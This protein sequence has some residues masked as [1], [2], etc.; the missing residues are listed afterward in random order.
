V[1]F[2][3]QFQRDGGEFFPLEDPFGR[4]CVDSD[5]DV[6]GCVVEEDHVGFVSQIVHLRVEGNGEI[7]LIYVETSDGHGIFA[8]DF[9]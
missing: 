8:E 7:I 6:L 2:S 1:F 3:A 9:D 4:R 5:V